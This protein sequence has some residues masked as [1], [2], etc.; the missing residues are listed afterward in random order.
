MSLPSWKEL[1]DSQD[2]KRNREPRAISHPAPSCL[3]SKGLPLRCPPAKVH[4]SPTTI[5]QGLS[6]PPTPKPGPALSHPS[7]WGATRE[8]FGLAS[9]PEPARGGVKLEPCLRKGEEASGTEQLRGHWLDGVETKLRLRWG[10]SPQ[11]GNGAKER[12]GT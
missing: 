12:E 1:R 10:L 3:P 4:S 6:P 9:W 5:Q 7:N 8:V 11:K 2:N